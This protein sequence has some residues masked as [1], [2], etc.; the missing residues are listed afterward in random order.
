MPGTTI[1]K[2]F[3]AFIGEVLGDHIT[4][5]YDLASLNEAIKKLEGNVQPVAHCGIFSRNDKSSDPD[6]E[7]QIVLVKKTEENSHDRLNLT[8]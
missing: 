6:P 3:E 4:C 5:Y 8:N 1:S 7:K 2:D